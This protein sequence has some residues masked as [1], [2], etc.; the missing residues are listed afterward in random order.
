MLLGLA[1][2]IPDSALA[3]ARR[4]LGA[5]GP[6]ATASAA[7]VVVDAVTAAPIRL[8]DDD[9]ELLAALLGRPDADI[10]G[11]PGDEVAPPPTFWFAPGP[12]S[13]LKE[14]GGRVG[15]SLD[16]TFGPDTEL[17]NDATI[18]LLGAVDSAVIAEV[19]QAA[20]FS[21]GLP[22]A[23]VGLWRA[24]RYAGVDDP[25]P[26]PVYLVE[27][28]PGGTPWV[29]TAAIQNVVSRLGVTAPSVE[30]FESWEPIGSYQAQA[31]SS[32]ALLWAATP[33]RPFQSAQVYD[34]VDEATGAGG[35][36]AGHPLIEDEDEAEAL[37]YYLDAGIAL[38][39]TDAMLDDVI[40]P[41]LRAC[42]PLNLRTD[43]EWIW[44]D[45]VFYYLHQHGLSPD[46]RLV[47]H[48]EE[49]RDPPPEMLDGVAL[50]RAIHHLERSPA[51]L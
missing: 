44:T 25:D 41:S 23:P 17:L 45:T 34:R 7:A 8:T 20:M 18:G 50:F 30:V 12:I 3:E 51:A 9:R 28:V 24:W 36:D 37:L 38:A 27:V 16:L 21:V 40:D 4:L 32:S 39:V 26:R 46:P 11:L 5:G 10:P 31:R 19:E 33:S 49:R 15:A 48:I 2:L 22:G 14:L 42:V 47:A 29:A 1:G 43:G 35:F 13:V 6:G